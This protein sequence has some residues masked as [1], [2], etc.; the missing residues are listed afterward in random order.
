MSHWRS[1]NG[2]SSAAAGMPPRRTRP[3]PG[4]RPQAA[5][6]S[7]A[8]G[9]GAG[10]GGLADGRLRAAPCTAFVL[11]RTSATKSAF[12]ERTVATPTARFSGT[13]RPPARLTACSAASA[14]AP[15]S[16]APRRSSFSYRGRRPRGE[17]HDQCQGAEGHQ[18]RRLR[19]PPPDAPSLRAGLPGSHASPGAKRVARRMRAGRLRPRLRRRP[20]CAAR[21][22]A[23]PPG[24]G[25]A[26][27]GA[28]PSRSCPRARAPACPSPERSRS[29]P[30]GG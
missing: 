29:P 26:R 7:I 9:S 13:T 24:G 23:A 11:G 12:V 20:P 2:S 5:M 14:E 4:A 16:T 21:R 19:T 30:P 22:R 6:R 25:A 17:R 3:S 15:R 28:G 27:A 10:G 18:K 1:A 8:N